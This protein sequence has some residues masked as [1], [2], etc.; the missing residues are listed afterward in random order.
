MVKHKIKDSR[1][2]VPPPRFDVAAW[3]G[4]W[5]S[6]QKSK[7]QRSKPGSWPIERSV[8]TAEEQKALKYNQTE[9]TAWLDYL[10]Y[11]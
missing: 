5:Q 8:C 11:L 4:F 6:L 1:K 3:F 9:H 10:T 2:K 7:T